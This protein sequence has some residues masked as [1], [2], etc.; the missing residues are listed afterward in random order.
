MSADSCRSPAAV[1]GAKAELADDLAF[2]LTTD[3]DGLREEDRSEE[4][5]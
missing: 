4:M 5:G 1:L 3:G 2:A